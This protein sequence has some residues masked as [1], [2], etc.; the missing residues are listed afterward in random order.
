ML[1]LVGGGQFVDDRPPHGAGVLQEVDVDGSVRRDVFRMIRSAV[2]LVEHAASRVLHEDGRV[3]DRSV[4]RCGRGEDRDL[5]VVRKWNGL[6]IR[7]WD[8]VL[9]AKAAQRA[10]E[11]GRGEGREQHRC[12]LVDPLLQERRV[13]MVAVQVRHVEVVRSLESGGVEARHCGGTRTTSRERPARTTGR[14]ARCH[15]WSR[16][17]TRRDRWP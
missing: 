5:E 7:A 10:L 11:L 16:R 17:T 12:R 4:G 13:E 6:A 15:P 14:R 2:V 3:T 8:E 9:E 1:R